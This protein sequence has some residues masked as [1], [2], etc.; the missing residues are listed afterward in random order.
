MSNQDSKFLGHF[1][2]TLCKMFDSSL[3]Y[4]SKAHLQTDGQTEMVNR[5]LG[6]I[7]QYICA[8][9]PKLWDLALA[10]SEFAYNSSV[11]R[12]MGK[13]LFVIVYTKTPR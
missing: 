7:I 6:N 4:S 9:K 10:Q 3:N 8:D 1:W 11:H 12:T 5:T 2:K 13:A